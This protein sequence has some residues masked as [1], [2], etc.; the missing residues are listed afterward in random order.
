MM[1]CKPDDSCEICNNTSGEMTVCR[2]CG[3]RV[4]L[5]CYLPEEGVCLTCSEARCYICN[6]YLASRA[7]NIC[8]NLVCEDHGTKIDEA[9]VCDNCRMRD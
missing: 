5:N 9:T 8:G 1:L 2:I 6:E 7:C 3:A 4:C